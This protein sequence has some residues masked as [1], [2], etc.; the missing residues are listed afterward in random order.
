M[1]TSKKLVAVIAM[2]S[3]L[4]IGNLAYAQ[5]TTTTAN[6]TVL[7][8]I[9]LSS[10]ALNFGSQIFPGTDKSIAKT[11]AAAAQ[12][13]ISGEPSK[14]VNT[15]FTLPSSM[16]ADTSSATMPISFSTTDAGYA[17]A[18]TSQSSQTAFDPSVAQSLTLDGTTGELYIWLGGTISPTSTQKKGSYTADITLDV[19]Y[20][21]N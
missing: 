8:P 12:F 20:P 17:A 6:G 4:I 1:N 9:S 16:Q 3:F 2:F 13:D 7:E 5:S 19:S 21:S 11:N 10:T 18:S 15:S 14:S